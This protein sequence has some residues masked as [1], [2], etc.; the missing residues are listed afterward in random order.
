MFRCLSLAGESQKVVAVE[1]Q[2]VVAVE[3]Q[4][5]VAGESQTVVAG[6]SQ[7]VVA[8]ESQKVIVVS[9]TENIL[10][11]TI[12][13]FWLSQLQLYPHKTKKHNLK[14]SS[15]KNKNRENTWNTEI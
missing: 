10:I 2:K 4:K 15:I 11:R 1:S 5:V 13:I 3:S 9:A 6:E 7:K 12:D 8:G 14:H